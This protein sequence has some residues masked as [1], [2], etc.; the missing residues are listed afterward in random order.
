MLV[1][2]HDVGFGNDYI[3]Q[4]VLLE[5]RDMGGALLQQAERPALG[6]S[7]ERYYHQYASLDLAWSLPT[8]EAPTYKQQKSLDGFWVLRVIGHGIGGKH[9]PA[10]MA[11]LAE[12]QSLE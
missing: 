10:K 1:L 2:G 9:I 7:H 3:H 11:Q 12:S 5:T 8:L 4:M 6:I